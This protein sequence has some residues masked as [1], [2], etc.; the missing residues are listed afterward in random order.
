MDGFVPPTRATRSPATNAAAYTS[1]DLAIPA[2]SFTAAVL[3]F[4]GT[5]PTKPWNGSP[6]DDQLRPRSSQT[7]TV[8]EAVREL[9]W[10]LKGAGVRCGLEIQI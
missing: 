3:V 6:F 10:Q 2:R 8:S 7:F 4:G 5:P 9:S 1:C